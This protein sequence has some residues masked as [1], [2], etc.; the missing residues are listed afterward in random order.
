MNFHKYQALGNT[1]LILEVDE[2]P[3]AA[4]IRTICHPSYGVG[5]DG[6]IVDSH[7]DD[8]HHF[9]A[10]FFNP[11][12][13]EA[14][15]SGNGLRIY[16]RYLWD[17]LEVADESF[18]IDT[19]GGR[20]Y[21]QVVENGR[22]VVLQMGEI[23]LGEP[24]GEELTLGDHLF[25]IYTA[26]AGNPHCVIVVDEA[27]A[28]LA[29]Q[30]G[31]LIEQDGRFPNRTNVQFVQ[32][33]DEQNIRLEIW[34]RGTGYTLASGTSSCAATAVLHRLGLCQRQVTVHMPGGMLTISLDEQN[35]ATLRGGVAKICS[36]HLSHDL[37][38][39]LG[40]PLPVE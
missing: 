26:D 16:A 4:Q 30:Y 18:T 15:K 17:S 23:R 6:L 31:P 38:R 10:Q 37:L 35:H 19:T 34:E 20:V 11:D 12:G 7:I 25:T 14:E 28:E 29:Q 36:G 3:T 39:T 40:L 27:T 13:S 32:V 1:Y 5:V 2:P 24:F 22:E 21:A 9:R 8:P 33:V